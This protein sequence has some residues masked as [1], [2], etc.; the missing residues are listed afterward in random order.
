MGS[1]GRPRSPAVQNSASRSVLADSETGIGVPS[2]SIAL[3]P[4]PRSATKR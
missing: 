2:A 1:D 4:A 3:A